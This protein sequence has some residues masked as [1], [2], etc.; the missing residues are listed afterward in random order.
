[1]ASLVILGGKAARPVGGIVRRVMNVCADMMCN[2]VGQLCSVLRGVISMSSW[3]GEMGKKGKVGG[4]LTIKMNDS[5]DG[6]ML[7]APGVPH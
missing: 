3:G 4:K 5:L 2:V 7:R 1:M 6:K